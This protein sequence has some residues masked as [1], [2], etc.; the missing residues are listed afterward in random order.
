MLDL[1]NIPAILN[2]NTDATLELRDLLLKNV[3]TQRQLAD[4][5][6]SI[7]TSMTTVYGMLTWPSFGPTRCS[8]APIATS[9]WQRRRR[10]SSR[11]SSC[12][13]LGVTG[14]EDM[15]KTFTMQRLTIGSILRV[16]DCV[17]LPS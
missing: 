6:P 13:L 5:R 15:V 14:T 3:A 9:T 11:C 12:S 7:N 4:A 8:A 1:G 17:G 16:G 10:S 2:I